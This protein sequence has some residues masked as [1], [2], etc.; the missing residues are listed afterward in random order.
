LPDTLTTIAPGAFGHYKQLI[1]INIPSSLETIPDATFFGCSSLL[2]IDIPEGVR[3]VDGSA[4]N[5]CTSLKSI[6]IPSTVTNEGLQFM[7]CQSLININVSE[8]NNVYSSEGGCLLNKEKTIVKS[9]TYLSVIPDGVNTIDSYAFY[10]LKGLTEIVIPSSVTTIGDFTFYG[11]SNLQTIRIKDGLET[12][13]YNAFANCVGIISIEVSENNT[14]YASEGNCLLNKTKTELIFGC[15]E[16]VIPQTVE[17]ILD[18]AFYGVVNLVDITIPQNVTKIG[19]YAFSGCENL[20]NATFENPN[21]WYAVYDE[22]ATTGT[23]FS[24][25]GADLSQTTVAANYLKSDNWSGY[26]WKRG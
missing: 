24:S 19:F 15:S 11:C 4:F 25:M 17:T 9:G 7:D 16:S 26:C 1:S 5:S 20:K 12:I 21:G 10:E 2:S 23:N 18:S 8:N 14:V 3:Y 6:S 22:S 13:G